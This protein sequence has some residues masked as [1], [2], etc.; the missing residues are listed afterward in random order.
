MLPVV[1]PSFES[2]PCRCAVGLPP[3]NPVYC[4]SPFVMSA[5]YPCK[6]FITICRVE[7]GVSKNSANETPPDQLHTSPEEIVTL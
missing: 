3:L 2:R 7:S 6:D 5:R 4:E 1:D